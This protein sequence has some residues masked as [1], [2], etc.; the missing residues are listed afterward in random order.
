MCGATTAAIVARVANRKLD[1]VTKFASLIAPPKYL[2][3]GIDLVTEGA[4]TLNQLNNII[5]LDESTFDDINPVTELYEL[6]SNADRTSLPRALNTIMQT[7]VCTFFQTGILTREKI[8][9]ILAKKLED[10]GK[11][12]IVKQV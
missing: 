5:D 3:D 6:I 1:I 12:V 9:P 8:I 7:K 10:K 11:L 2:I 4:V